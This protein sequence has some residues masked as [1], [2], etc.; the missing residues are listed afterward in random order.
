MRTTL[1]LDAKLLDEAMKATGAPTKTAT[2]H[3][4][5]E[6]LVEAS[7]RR[8]LAAL[9]GQIPAAEASPRRRPAPGSVP[10][11]SAPR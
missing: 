2:V 11:D 4:G 1:D 3:L 5:L 6:A 7:A 9:K 8:R 10:S